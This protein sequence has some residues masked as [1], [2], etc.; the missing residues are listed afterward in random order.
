MTA[1]AW[2]SRAGAS[3][4]QLG[5]ASGAKAMTTSARRPMCA[6]HD[7]SAAERCFISASRPSVRPATSSDLS[8]IAIRMD[9]TCPLWLPERGRSSARA[10]RARCPRVFRTCREGRSRRCR[11]SVE[12]N[13]NDLAQRGFFGDRVRDDRAVKKT[14]L[15]SL[16]WTKPLSSSRFS[17]AR[18]AEPLSGSGSASQISVTSSGPAH[19]GYRRSVVRG[20]GACSASSES[21]SSGPGRRATFVA[22]LHL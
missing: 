9:I 6:T 11:R 17:M 15:R 4:V 22:L 10:R 18:T 8:A 1:G 5:S 2:P 13:S 19:R 20:A 7:R 21:C 12:E 16:R 14:S 3:T